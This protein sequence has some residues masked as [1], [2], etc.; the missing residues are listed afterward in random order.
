[1]IKYEKSK[2][3]AVAVKNFVLADDD[4]CVASVNANLEPDQDM[5]VCIGM[6][7]EYFFSNEDSHFIYSQEY[8]YGFWVAKELVDIKEVVRW[9]NHPLTNGQ[10]VAVK[11]FAMHM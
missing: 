1:M 7:F 8:T 2:Y 9:I 4:Y 6:E 11:Y 5:A 3:K 10:T